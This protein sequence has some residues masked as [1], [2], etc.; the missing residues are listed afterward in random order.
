MSIRNSICLIKKAF[1]QTLIILLHNISLPSQLEMSNLKIGTQNL[2]TS[3][4]VAITPRG[5]F[6]RDRVSFLLAIKQLDQAYSRH[7][8]HHNHENV[9]PWICWLCSRIQWLSPWTQYCNRVTT[10]LVQSVVAHCSRGRGGIFHDCSTVSMETVK[11]R[12]EWDRYRDPFAFIVVECIRL[13][14]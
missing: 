11:P 2:R 7:M 6:S 9:Y 10:N 3:D 13:W 4:P 14:S 5:S 1:R 8:F 12:L